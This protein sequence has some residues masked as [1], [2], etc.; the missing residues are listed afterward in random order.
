MAKSIASDVGL[1]N[2]WLQEF[3]LVSFKSL[4]AEL[5]PLRRTA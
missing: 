1:T 5:A 2:A 3:G 4:W